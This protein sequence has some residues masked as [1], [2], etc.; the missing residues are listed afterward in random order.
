MHGTDGGGERQAARHEAGCTEK[1]LGIKKRM[2]AQQGFR[3]LRDGEESGKER[4][5][6]KILGQR[7]QRPEIKV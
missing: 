7:L 3:G 6:I 5:N 2:K 1:G 4:M